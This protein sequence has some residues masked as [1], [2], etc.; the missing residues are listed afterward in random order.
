MLNKQKTHKCSVSALVDVSF[1]M[2][3]IIAD[4]QYNA[5]ILLT[6]TPWIKFF[7]KTKSVIDCN[8]ILSCKSLPGAGRKHSNFFPISSLQAHGSEVSF[9]IFH[10][11]PLRQEKWSPSDICSWNQVNYDSTLPDFRLSWFPISLWRLGYSKC[12]KELWFERMKYSVL[13]I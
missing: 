6:Q 9:Y 4:T 11:L 2:Q 8:Y 13:L 1:C 10:F 5:N 7:R 3:K 12:R